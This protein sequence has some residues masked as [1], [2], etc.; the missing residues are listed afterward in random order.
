MAEKEKI[1]CKQFKDGSSNF[2]VDNIH[3]HLDTMGE[4]HFC[5]GGIDKPELVEYLKAFIKRNKK[6]FQPREASIF[7]QE[8]IEYSKIGFGKYSQMSTMELVATDR[9][10]A[11]WLYEKTTD[12]KIK[13][14]L[15]QLLK[16]K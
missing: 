15:K 6:T 10:Y 5:A 3:Y 11:K 16:I 2:W 9:S 4:I 13:E 12:T 1:S 7:E 8:E 14:E